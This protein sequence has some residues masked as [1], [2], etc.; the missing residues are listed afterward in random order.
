MK[1]IVQDGYGS[2]D[3]LQLREID[4]P[5]VTEGGVLVR[6]RAASVNARDWHLMRGDP[7]VARPSFGLRRPR[8]KIRGTDFA[9]RVEAVGPD[10]QRFRPGDEVFGEADGAFAEYVCAPDGVVEPKPANLTFEQAAAVPLAGNTALMGVRD[11]ARVEP[12]QQVLINGA[13]GGVGT[14]AVQIAKSF[15]AEVTGVCSTR[16]LELI[17]S[18]GADHVIDYTVEDFTRNGRQYDVVFDLVGNRSLTDFRRALTPEG[19]LVLSGGGV[20]GGGSLFGPMGLFVKG[21]LMARFVHHRL[22][23]LTVKP[24]QENLAT[25]RE[26]A[27]SGKIAPVIDRTYPLSETPEAIRYLEVEHARAKVV[28]TV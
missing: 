12:G 28:I 20:S 17:R 3:V 10:V 8:V 18:L 19:T 15:G 24:S 1:A 21:Q 25:L 22:L 5:V 27:E 11:V 7:Y 26:L 6:V 9:G 4:K 13:S 16:N 2:A 14:F 23:P